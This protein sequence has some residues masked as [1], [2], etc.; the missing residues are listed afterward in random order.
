MSEQQPPL[1]PA[2]IGKGSKRL[3][4]L[5]AT[6]GGILGLAGGVGVVSLRSVSGAY[7]GGEFGGLATALEDLILFPLAGGLGGLILG[8]LMGLAFLHS[9]PA[10][11]PG[12]RQE[13]PAPPATPG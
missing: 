3:P 4:V 10:H 6:A 13:P 12:C 11:Q 9:G 8:F 2:P 1:D 5:W 7:A